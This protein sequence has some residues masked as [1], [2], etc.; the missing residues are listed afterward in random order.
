MSCSSCTPSSSQCC[1]SSTQ[2]SADLLQIITDLAS[3]KYSYDDESLSLLCEYIVDGNY[4]AHCK[5][6]Q[7]FEKFHLSNQ[8]LLFFKLCKFFLFHSIRG[9]FVYWMLEEVREQDLLDEKSF[10]YYESKDKVN[11]LIKILNMKL[12]EYLA[13]NTTMKINKLSPVE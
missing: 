2:E 5:I 7:L 10:I 9:V 11:M 4:S 12:D 13:F 3:G 8:D 6:L 1:S